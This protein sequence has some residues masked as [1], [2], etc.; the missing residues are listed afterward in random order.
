M[1]YQTLTIIGNLAKLNEHDRFNRANRFAGAKL[2][3]DMTELVSS[4]AGSL[5]PITKPIIIGFHWYISS[6]HDP[7]NIA[8]AKKYI[9]DGL[10]HAKKLP[11]DDQKWVH[12]FSGDSF[13][14][15]SK[16]EEKIIIDIEDSTLVS[17]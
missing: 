15:V 11:N 17:I 10:I 7:D 14:K 1:T 3:K 16:G 12:G 2:K 4:Q 6:R 8:F 13:H 9:L 5:K